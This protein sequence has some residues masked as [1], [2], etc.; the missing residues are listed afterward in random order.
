M[1]DDAPGVIFDIKLGKE[2][3]KTSGIRGVMKVLVIHWLPQLVV[4]GSADA[5]LLAMCESGEG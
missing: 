1:L 4:S 5:A 3:R 2:I